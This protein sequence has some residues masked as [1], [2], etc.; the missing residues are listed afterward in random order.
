[1]IAGSEKTSPPTFA[2]EL[3]TLLAVELL[4]TLEKYDLSLEK[5]PFFETRFLIKI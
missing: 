5:I 1:M 4:S 3:M 2:Q